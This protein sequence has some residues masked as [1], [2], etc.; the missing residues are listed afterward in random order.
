[1]L[2]RK[3]RKASI[4]ISMYPVTL[5]LTLLKKML[6]PKGSTKISMYPVTLRLTLFK[7]AFTCNRPSD[8]VRL[9]NANYAIFS[10]QIVRLERPIM[11]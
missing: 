11:R 5:R 3:G 6:L 7:N 2:Y 1:M 10:E 9:K 4:E 8:R